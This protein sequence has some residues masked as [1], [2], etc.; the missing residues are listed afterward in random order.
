MPCGRTAA[1]STR[2]R[3]ADRCVSGAAASRRRIRK[4]WWTAALRVRHPMVLLGRGEITYGKHGHGATGAAAHVL[5]QRPGGAGRLLPDRRRLL[6]VLFLVWIVNNTA[7][8]LRRRTRLRASTSCGRRPAS[9]S[10]SRCS[11]STASFYWEAFLVGLT[12][13]IL[14][15]HRHRLRHDPRLHHRHRAAVVQLPGL[16]TCDRL[17]RDHP[18]HPAAA[19]AVLLVLRRPQGDAGG[20]GLDC[21]SVR[22]VHQPAWTVRP[23]AAV[24]RAVRLGAG[25]PGLSIVCMDRH[26]IWARRRLERRGRRFPVFLT[27]LAITVVLVAAVWLSAVP[28]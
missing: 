7:V 22:H 14:V 15:A 12:N 9:T 11:T 20:A 21:S 13:T 28:R 18:Q 3:S 5:P 6:V 25:R 17:R 27:G 4:R 8:N 2:R 26:R 10:A 23:P 16:A 24:R 19:A 1:S